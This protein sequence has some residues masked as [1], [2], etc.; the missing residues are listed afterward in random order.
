VLVNDGFTNLT[1]GTLFDL[2]ASTMSGISFVNMIT[3]GGASAKFLDGAADSANINAGGVGLLSNCHVSGP[4]LL[5]S[6]ISVNNSRWEFTGND[7]VANT[8]PDGLLTLIGNSTATVIAAAGTAVLVA[9]TWVVETV[10]QSTGT[11]AGRYTYNGSKNAKLPIMIEVT[12]TPVSGAA[13]AMSAYVAING[14]IVANSRR[15]APLASG[16]LIQVISI[17]WQINASGND[18]VEVF[19]ANDSSTVNLL[20]SSAVMRIN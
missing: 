11:T 13:I 18:Y 12:V 19:V 15:E 9:G 14:A 20:V 8:R 1:A 6:N 2:S 7:E 17:P 10:S 4:N 16:G 5:G 3:R